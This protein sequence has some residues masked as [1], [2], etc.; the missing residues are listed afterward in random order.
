MAGQDGQ[1]DGQQGTPGA[2]RAWVFPPRFDQAGV[3]LTR[4][5]WATVEQAMRVLFMTQPGERVM[6]EEYGCDL[7]A[8]MFRNI[9]EA[10]LAEVQAQLQ[11]SVRRYVPQVTLE[12]VNVYPGEAEPG[13]LDVMVAY[14][15]PQTDGVRRVAGRLDIADAQVGWF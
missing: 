8:V 9:G 4:A 15:L 12:S 10:L 13:Q 7:Q 3:Q 1:Q 6:R 2:L 11:D 5:G 14:R